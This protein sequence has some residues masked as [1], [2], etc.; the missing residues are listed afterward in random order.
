MNALVVVPTYNERDNLRPLVD[1]VLA[2]AGT[3]MLVIDDRSP[4]GTGEVADALAPEAAGRP[5]GARYLHGVS[6]VNWPLRRIVL[7]AFANH[8]VRAVTR[9][10]V[11]DCTSGFRCWRREALGRLQDVAGG[12]PRVGA[13]ALAAAPRRRAA[14]ALET[15]TVLRFGAS[16][17]HVDT[18]GRR[19][20]IR[21]EGL[22]PPLQQ[23]RPGGKPCHPC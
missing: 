22:L 10:S 23:R 20:S 9:L 19:G 5:A 12:H 4:A 14:L 3:R 8:Y 7:S 1:G 18:K 17:R 6:V 11:R 16:A 13:H 2:H 15:T 21:L